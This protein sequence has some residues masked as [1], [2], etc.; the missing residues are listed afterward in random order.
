MARGYSH[1]QRSHVSVKS[2][3]SETEEVDIWKIITLQKFSIV[4][5]QQTSYLSYLTTP[6]QHWRSVSALL[7][8]GRF[9]GLLLVALVFL[10]APFVSTTFIGLLLIGCAGLWFLLLLSDGRQS[11]LSPI[12]LAVMVY[13]LY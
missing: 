9:V 13:F 8:Q 4:T 5:W 3:V 12:H 11:V 1:H 2:R 10:A 6:L 7:S